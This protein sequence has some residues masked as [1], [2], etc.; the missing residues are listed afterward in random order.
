[1]KNLHMLRFKKAARTPLLGSA[2]LLVLAGCAS[3][4]APT[5]QMAVAEA[6]VATAKS[7]N[8]SEHAPGELQV[9]IAKLTSARDA[10]ARKDYDAARRYAEQAELDARVAQVRAQSVSARKAA[11]ESQEAARVLRE[12]LNRNT[13]N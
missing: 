1:M 11:Q 5:S 9:A 3:T 6:A 4:P 2:L 7:S 12:E 13:Y 8:T 10:L